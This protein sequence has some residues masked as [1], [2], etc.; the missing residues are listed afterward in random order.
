MKN[1][2]KVQGIL[3]AILLVIAVP[4]NA[5]ASGSSSI[6][7]N[8]QTYLEY[9]GEHLKDSSASPTDNSMGNGKVHGQTKRWIRSTLRE[10][11]VDSRYIYEQ[12]FNTQKDTTGVISAPWG[13]HVFFKGSNIEVT[14]KGKD[15]SKQIIVSAH[16]DGSGYS[17]NASGVALML[18]QIKEL[19]DKKSP[20]AVKLPY[21]VKFVFFDIE[22]FN[23]GS[24]YYAKKMTAADKKNTLFI[25]SIDNIA[26]GDYPNVY[27]GITDPNNNSV[28]HT[29]AYKL[30][31]SKAL[32]LGINVFDTE[33]L[34][35]YYNTHGKGPEISE[36]T[37]YTNPWTSSNPSPGVKYS[38]LSPSYP[39]SRSHM[40]FVEA[41]IPYAS[42][43][44]SNWFAKSMDGTIYEA[45]NDGLISQVRRDFY[46]SG[47]KEHD[48]MKILEA[49]FPGR[50]LAHYNVYGPLLNK[51][52]MEPDIEILQP[53]Q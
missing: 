35:G 52:L 21:T 38:V 3:L 18:A 51:M 30:A 12:N 14:L 9:M 2:L 34:D 28:V 37:I 6:A 11:G 29:E 33:A 41:G 5:L 40:L 53:S 8:A 25:L 27:G 23:K 17:N 24:E 45:E 15:P 49:Y 44:A 48:T 16:Y 20:H 7:T 46:I 47:G 39:I 36:N 4:G 26:R 1:I 13:H 10:I 50:S 43:Q 19:V 32:E 31:V 42:F 22:Q